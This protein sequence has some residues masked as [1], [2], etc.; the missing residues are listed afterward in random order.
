ML[1]ASLVIG[2]LIGFS[3]TSSDLG[4]TQKTVAYFGE[5]GVVQ[6]V[7]MG[8]DSLDVILEDLM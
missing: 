2:I 4:T 8:E 5:D 1:A 7:V 6:Q 3:A